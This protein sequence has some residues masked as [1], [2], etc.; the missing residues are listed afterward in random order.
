[1]KELATD[2]SGA[3]TTELTMALADSQ[4]YIV[5]NETS[6]RIVFVPVSTIE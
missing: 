5:G 4:S 2:L 6:Y 1:L 3:N